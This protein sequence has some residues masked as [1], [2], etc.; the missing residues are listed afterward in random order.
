[1]DN[2]LKLSV[3]DQYVFEMSESNINELDAIPTEKNKFH[4]IKGNSSFNATVFNSD[5]IQ[6][7]NLST[8]IQIEY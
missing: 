3:N 2:F 8:W 1:M 4:I 7:I 5:F 6:K